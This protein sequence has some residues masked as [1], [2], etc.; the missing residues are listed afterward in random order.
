MSLK[1]GQ[2]TGLIAL[3]AATDA[4]ISNPA[5]GKSHEFYNLI[6]HDTGAAGD[7]VELFLSDDA[8]SAS[9]ERIDKVILGAGETKRF[10]PVVV[11]AGKY[12]IA[13]AATATITVHGE[14]IY[15]DGADV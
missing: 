10:M 14:Y 9:G 8:T 13:K 7:T 6:A 12:L 4:V 2:T 11:A 3:A 15:R 5:S 1:S